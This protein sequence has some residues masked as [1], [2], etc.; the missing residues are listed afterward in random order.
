MPKSDS[1]SKLAESIDD[2]AMDVST[3]VETAGSKPK[4]KK[5]VV[6]VDKPT[7]YTFDLGNLL[8][9]DPN[10]VPADADEATVTA[11]AR[12]A[13]QVLI[14][15][16]LTTCDIKSTSDGVTLNL[17]APST[18][19]PREKPVPAAKPPTTWEKFAAKK[20]IKDKKR[21]EG[22]MVYD[23]ATGEWVPK[24]GYK[25]KN[26]DGDDQWLVEVDEKKEMET[27]VAHNARAD[28]R[29]E[30]KEKVRRNERKQRANE[31]KAGKGGS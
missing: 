4:N 13:A 27:G 17:P 25:G 11:I 18:P 23:E 31:R 9:I 30:R 26:K 22:K 7:P 16:L 8:A 12:D 2:G 20:G 6:T 14:N 19:I 5:N 21:G 24:W 15:Q 1:P 29:R 28:G 3:P 10:P